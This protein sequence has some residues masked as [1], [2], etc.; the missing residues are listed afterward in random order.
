MICHSARCLTVAGF[1]LAVGASGIA[2]PHSVTLVARDVD[3]RTLYGVDI[4]LTDAAAMVLL[5]MASM[6]DG[7]TEVE[8]MIRGYWRPQRNR[9]QFHTPKR[10]S[11]VARMRR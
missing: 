6:V 2:G 8:G 3:R 10:I 5:S 4:V 7:L 9:L 1:H 11:S